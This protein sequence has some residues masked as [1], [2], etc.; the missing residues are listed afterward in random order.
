[1]SEPG[2]YKESVASYGRTADER[3]LKALQN[4]NANLS[5]WFRED[6]SNEELSAM[7]TERVPGGA[8]HIGNDY[9]NG[10]LRSRIWID[11]QGKYYREI[12]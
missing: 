4:R 9:V 3:L 1:M 11:K 8:R 6:F 5:P 12:Y 2:T 10:D 7:S